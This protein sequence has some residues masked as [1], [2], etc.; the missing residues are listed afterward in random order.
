MDVIPTLNDIAQDPACTGTLPPETLARLLAQVAAVQTAIAA[1]LLAA[2]VNG[3]S[4]PTGPDDEML[5][6]A[7]TA[8]LLRRSER[9]IYRHPELPFIK[10]ISSRSLLCSKA[11]IEK[12]L[13]SRK[14]RP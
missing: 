1:R 2:P 9:W 10:R 8:K 13:A 4:A 11:G 6:V 3:T 12:W 5:T 7:E 14:A